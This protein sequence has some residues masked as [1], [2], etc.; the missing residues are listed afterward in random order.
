M[1]AIPTP[2]LPTLPKD[3]VPVPLAGGTPTGNVWIPGQNGAPA[4]TIPSTSPNNP[5]ATVGNGNPSDPLQSEIG[6]FPGVSSGA[7]PAGTV[8]TTPLTAATPGGQPAW[9]KSNY[10]T[11]LGGGNQSNPSGAK[12][13]GPPDGPSTNTGVPATTAKPI[14]PGGPTPSA[15]ALQ[16]LSN[17]GWQQDPNDPTKFTYIGGDPRFAGNQG[18][19]VNGVFTNVT[20]GGQVTLSDDGQQ[21][22][23][24]GNPFT[25]AGGGGQGTG[26][27]TAP[28][29]TTIPGG[30][31]GVVPTTSE[32]QGGISIVSPQNP[33]FTS[34]LYNYLAQ[35]LGKGA[36]PFDASSYMPSTG[37]ISDPGQLTAAL[38]PLMVQLQNFFQSGGQS[39]NTGLS[40]LQ[41]LASGQPGGQAGTTLNYL[42]GTGGNNTGVGVN[43]LTGAA[44]GN[45]NA[46]IDPNALASLQSM[47]AAGDPAALERIQGLD[48]MNSL[49]ATGLP[50]DVLPQWQ[51]MIDAQ[52][53]NISQQNAQ[54]RENM[55]STG[56]LQS[57]VYGQALVDF[58]SQTAK[59]QNAL[60]AQ[61]TQQ[62]LEAARNRQATA[63]PGLANLTAGLQ[64]SA[65]NR[66]VQSAA[67]LAG[68]SAN[69]GV[70]N[71]QIQTGAGGQMAGITQQ[72]IQNQLASSQFL[73]GLQPQAAS[74][75]MSAA[76][77]LASALQSMDQTS[78]QAT[79]QEFIRTRPE[80][81]PLMNM[82]FGLA[83]TFPP[84]AGK[85]GTTGIVGQLIS[86]APQLASTISSAIQGNGGGGG[87]GVSIPGGS[88]GVFATPPFF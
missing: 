27:V 48:T 66:K 41:G 25:G 11:M 16:T 47:A 74:T 49:A 63:A 36:T 88:G 46:Q 76:G 45:L 72:Q 17:D 56:N 82:I 61:M 60:L 5:F 6:M 84:T 37:G 42:A 73:A 13:P 2:P 18:T 14:T 54:L 50:T 64:E 31:G 52:Q 21:G 59:D 28:P 85:T 19:Y 9:A 43:T 3:A 77:T 20:Y 51:A 57:S 10:T 68:V 81:G 35:M 75:L 70:A 79:L 23:Y 32:P 30:S 69:T 15:A 83:T 29:G 86:A 78:V 55:A 33:Q 8:P 12:P 1:A 26:A 53:R 71:A 34:Q 87:G 39:T 62:S 24:T 80:Y 40:Q 22:P 67:D 58:N 38:N 44:Q 65:A 7:A 4:Y